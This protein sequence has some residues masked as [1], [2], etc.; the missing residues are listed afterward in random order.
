M[1]CDERT[2]QAHLLCAECFTKAEWIEPPF[3]VAC[4]LPFAFTIG[5][6]ALCG[7]CMRQPPQFAAAR[8][9]MRYGDVSGRL[10]SHLKFHDRLDLASGLARLMARSGAELIARSDLIIAVPLHRRRLRQRRYNQSAQLAHGLSRISNL[11]WLRA[12]LERARPTQPQS[13]LTRAERLRNVSRAFRVAPVH[14]A[15]IR[16]KRI[17][18]V[19]DVMTTGATLASCTRAL[20]AAGAAEV[21]V[22]TLART[23]REENL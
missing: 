2:D 15:S 1:A 21:R 14:A 3:C 18:L 23:T 17:L 19:D 12:P 22:L 11:P 4:G 7:E 10:V 13:G 16:E 9:V 5:D 20:L 6:K 8:A